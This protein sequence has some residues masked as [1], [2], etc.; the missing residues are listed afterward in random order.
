MFKE[1]V[2]DFVMLGYFNCLG[3][4]NTEN[5]QKDHLS[6]HFLFIARM[7]RY[8]SIAGRP[9]KQKIGNIIVRML[10]KPRNQSSKLGLAI[11]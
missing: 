9:P 10:L 11:S 1:Q 8:W 4:L 2:E 7:S 5:G 3:V 6:I